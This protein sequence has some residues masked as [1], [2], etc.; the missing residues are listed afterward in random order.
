[1]SEL[2][3]IHEAMFGYAWLGAHQRGDSPTLDREMAAYEGLADAVAD[4]V[5]P[6]GSPRAA[7][8]RGL[9]DFLTYRALRQSGRLSEQAGRGRTGRDHPGTHSFRG[10]VTHPP[11]APRRAP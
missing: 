5:T 6:P 11:Q 4:I 8:I 2:C 10:R 3:R 7:L 9:L 1:M